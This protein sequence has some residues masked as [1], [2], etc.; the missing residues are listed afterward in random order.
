MIKI[1]RVMFIE[2]HLDLICFLFTLFQLKKKKV[3]AAQ[4]RTWDLSSLTRDQTFIPCT[5]RPES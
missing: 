5:G 4:R 2:V 3:L 1:I